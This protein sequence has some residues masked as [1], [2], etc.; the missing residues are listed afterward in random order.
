MTG[1]YTSEAYSDKG[2]LIIWVDSVCL[3]PPTPAPP[4]RICN[5]LASDLEWFLVTI[6]HF[7]Q[8][9]RMYF[10]LAVVRSPHTCDLNLLLKSLDIL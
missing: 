5:Y 2:G 4:K 8:S 1:S 10:S 3:P 9:F 7:L 6:R